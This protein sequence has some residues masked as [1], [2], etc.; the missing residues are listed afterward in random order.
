LRY[1]LTYKEYCWGIRF[2]RMNVGLLLK[3]NLSVFES[4]RG[5]I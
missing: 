3:N 4:I 2:R 1:K 5:D